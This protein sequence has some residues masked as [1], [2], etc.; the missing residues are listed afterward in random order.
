MLTLVIK[1]DQIMIWSFAFRQWS[2]CIC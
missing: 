1:Q 2:L